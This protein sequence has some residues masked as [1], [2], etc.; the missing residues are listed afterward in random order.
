MIEKLRN[1]VIENNTK[2]GRR[3]DLFIQSLI[4]LALISFSF[5]TLPNLDKGTKDLLD[6][7]EIISIC[8]FSVEY[9]LRVFLTKK[10][11]RYITCMGKL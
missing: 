8:I 6:N 1:I 10:S 5:E 7:F 4:L 9:L 11:F 2:F 3:F